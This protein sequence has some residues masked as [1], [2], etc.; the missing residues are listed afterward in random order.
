MKKNMA[1]CE[2][3]KGQMEDECELFIEFLSLISK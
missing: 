2:F 1:S 3:E